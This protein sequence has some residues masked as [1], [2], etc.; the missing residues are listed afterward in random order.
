[1]QKG[2]TFV[3]PFLLEKYKFTGFVSGI[4]SVYH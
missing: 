2:V 3:T 4:Q 1:M